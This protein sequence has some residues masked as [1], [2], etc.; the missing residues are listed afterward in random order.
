[1]AKNRDIISYYLKHFPKLESDFK[2]ARE[3]LERDLYMH[4]A[5]HEIE[6]GQLHTHFEE[7]AQSHLHDYTNREHDYQAALNFIRCEYVELFAGIDAHVRAHETDVQEEINEENAQ[8]NQVMDTIDELKQEAYQHYLQLTLEINQRIDHEMQVHHDFIDMENERLSQTFL[9]YQNINSD[10]ANQLLWTIESSKYALSE[11]GK[12]LG[13][14]QMNDT[15]FMNESILQTLEKLR[16]TKNNLTSIFKSTSEVFTHHMQSILKLSHERQKPHTLLNQTNIRQFVKKIKDVNHKRSVFEAMIRAELE[17]SLK[18]IGSRILTYDREGNRLQLEKA[19][20]Q[21]EI[22]QKKAEYLLHRNQAMTDMFISKYQNEIKKIK[23]D[24]FQRT[25]EIKLAYLMPASFIQNSIDLYSNFAFYTNETFAELDNQLSDL[26][27]YNQR[28]TESKYQY[29]KQSAKTVEDYKIR[30]I[31][32]I[33]G[34]TAKLTDMIS[35]IDTLSKNIIT[36]ESQNQLEIAEIRKQM[37][38]ADVTGDYDKYVARLDNDAYFACYQH[39]INTQKIRSL[40]AYRENL[41]LVERSVTHLH[42][43]QQLLNVDL[44]HQLA[45][46]DLEKE[47]RDIAFERELTYFTKIHNHEMVSSGLKEQLAE[48]D[49][50][51]RFDSIN[52]LYA[53]KY[54]QLHINHEN[55]KSDGSDHVIEYIHRTQS[56]LDLN[57]RDHEHFQARIAQSDNTREYAYHLEGQRERIKREVN[58]QLER[59]VLK[60]RQAIQMYHHHLFTAQAS[61]AQLWEPHIIRLKHL[62]M[63]LDTAN[64][65]Q[66]SAMIIAHNLF[67]HFVCHR[68]DLSF[69]HARQAIMEIHPAY[70]GNELSHTHHRFFTQYCILADASRNALMRKRT[71]PKK[72]KQTLLSFYV[73]S[74]TFL[75]SLKS[76]LSSAIDKAE[77]AI[78]HQDVLFI[79]RAN[80]HAAHTL[81]MIDTYYDQLIYQAVNIGK[82]KRRTL[83]HYQKDIH[84][85]E[86]VFKDKVLAV[87]QSYI[88][89]TQQNEKQLAFI[90]KELSKIIDDNT[91]ARNMM[92]KLEKSHYESER[93]FLEQRQKAYQ[94]VYQLLKGRNEVVASVESALIKQLE[95]QRTDSISRALKRLEQRTYELS[96]ERQLLVNRI[97][98]DKNQ[99]ITKRMELLNQQM[100]AIEGQ[101][102]TSRPKYLEAIS[103]VKKRL[104]DDY[105]VLYKQ[106]QK[107]QESFLSQ[108]VETQTLFSHDLNHFLQSQQSNRDI[109]DNDDITL[110]PFVAFDEIHSLLI[111]KTE[112]IF[113][114]TVNKNDLTRTK[115]ASEETQA[116]EKQKRIING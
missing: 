49:I 85:L 111:E 72:A 35:A 46:I 6:L 36:L 53:R 14:D 83:S 39:D 101:K 38:N 51:Y 107:A 47:I 74:L 64:A 86:R 24:S 34:V 61:I 66:Q 87:N 113:K 42:L 8:F 63:G 77:T 16:E 82:K 18:I 115:I 98:T 94:R 17:R 15:K 5:H 103:S 28:I 48:L 7:I 29:I 116:K 31:A 37:E 69:S 52:H 26:I 75:A 108:Y 79:D 95:S 89:Y 91:H 3:K 40:A 78:I 44:T 104:P 60:S 41:L 1:M 81:K 23:V 109:I 33:N 43:E 32:Q 21:Y 92:L 11:L 102:F 55:Q 10:Q 19:I 58:E 68:I 57:T 50:S 90:K 54:Q 84:K 110:K 80:A 59:K 93:K 9:D 27:A 97:D 65:T 70:D 22:V 20:M 67:L 112:T 13:H 99:L 71:S 96:S 62:L 76:T 2:N 106:I 4:L 30:V 88:T 105:Y 73:K 114:E 45:L 56:I 100:A 12:Q 25:E